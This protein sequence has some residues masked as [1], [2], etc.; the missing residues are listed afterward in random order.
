MRGPD[1]L[2]TTHIADRGTLRPLDR[3]P[4]AA[5]LNHGSGGM[6]DF[7][8]GVFSLRS[9]LVAFASGLAGFAAARP[10]AK[11]IWTRYHIEK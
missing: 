8:V 4:S 9:V 2:I 1:F 3:H 5:R 11:R 6:E 7:V 10:G